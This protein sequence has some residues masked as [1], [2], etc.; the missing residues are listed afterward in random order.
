MDGIGSTIV[1]NASDEFEEHIVIHPKNKSLGKEASTTTEVLV[2][3]DLVPSRYPEIAQDIQRID[4][5]GGKVLNLLYRKTFEPVFSD[6]EQVLAEFGER[7]DFIKK[8]LDKIHEIPEHFKKKK[9]ISKLKNEVFFK[10]ETL[11]SE[12][13]K[14]KKLTL[15]KENLEK[16]IAWYQNRLRND[17]LNYPAKMRVSYDP[18]AFAKDK[19]DASGLKMYKFWK[20]AKHQ[21][22]GGKM[23]QKVNYREVARYYQL[24]SREVFLYSILERFLD[25]EGEFYNDIRSITSSM[26][27]NLADIERKIESDNPNWG[28]RDFDLL[29]ER[30]SKLLTD[31]SQ[32]ARRYQMRL[33]VEYRKNLQQMSDVLEEVGVDK[34]VS[35]KKKSKKYYAGIAEKTEEF[36][37]A[38]EVKFKTMLNKVLMELAVN[39]VNNRLEN[40]F[41]E[42]KSELSQTVKTKYLRGLSSIMKQIRC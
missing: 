33:K 35:T 26:I 27:A 20:R 31:R 13:F 19:T 24:H 22:F 42:Y 2:V 10:I 28:A 17:F 9:A 30:I 39:R 7:V 15:H 4:V 36:S 23:T 6:H 40:L 12:E 3:P 14:E 38:Y 5:N 8:E 18:S 21:V 16:G 34:L 37:G 25:E 32:T 29:S 11:I 1:L 41:E